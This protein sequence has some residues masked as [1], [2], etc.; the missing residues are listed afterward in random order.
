MPYLSLTLSLSH[1]FTSLSHSFT[2]LQIPSRS[3][4][5]TVSHIHSLIPTLSHSLPYTFSFS[6]TLSLTLSLSLSLSLS[7]TVILPHSHIHPFFQPLSLSLS[8]T[9]TDTHT[10]THTHTHFF[11][12]Y[13]SVFGTDYTIKIRQKLKVEFFDNDNTSFTINV[14]QSKNDY[15]YSNGKE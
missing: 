3:H 7:H 11:Q 5:F 13:F 12:T 14:A 6:H 4:R 8:H 9:H 15:T 10:H 2:L 1:T